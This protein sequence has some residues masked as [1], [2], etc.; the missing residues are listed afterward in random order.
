EDQKEVRAGLECGMTIRNFND[1]KTG[2]VIESYVV[3]EVKATL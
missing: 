1:L 2:D 3:N